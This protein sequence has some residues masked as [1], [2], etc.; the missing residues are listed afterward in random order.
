MPRTLSLSVLVGIVAV[1]ACSDVPTGVTLSTA[2]DRAVVTTPTSGIWART[3]VG[4]TGP[5]SSYAVYIPR[6]WNGDAVEYAHGFRDAASPVDLRDQDNL[7]AIRDL[8]GGL[9]YA[10]AYSS[11]DENGLAVK[12]GIQRTHQLRGLLAAQLGGRL[13]AHN[14]LVGSSL[15]GGIGV[16]LAEHYPEQYDGAFLMCGM[17]GGTLLQTQY[18]GH[19]RAL[20]D[21]FYPG[22]MPGSVLGVPAGEPIPTTEQVQA[23]VLGALPTNPLALYAIASTRQTPLPYVPG[24]NVL[25]PS[26]A[27]FQTMVYSLAYAVAWHARG[28]NNVLELTHGHTPFDN[29]STDYALGTPVVP[30]PLVP[31]ISTMIDDADAH[32]GRYTFDPSALNY[33]QQWYTPTGDVR[34]PVLT[35]HNTFDPGV[36]AFHEAALLERVQA[37]G[38]SDMLV[39]RYYPYAF[40]HCALPPSVV[41]QSFQDLANW[42][43]LGT[44]PAP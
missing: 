33:L 6:S 7:Y 2:A 29:H 27:S 36:P 24:G 32:V 17:V 35:L 9:G 18:V 28:M 13:P 25:D 12:D 31:T 10:V 41:V 20:F 34:I 4:Q 40:G 8:L 15:G 19:V 43:R 44:R 22:A 21:Y 42:A 37:A 30:A 11:F 39:Q 16:Y 14:F 26:S 3:V 1:A 23:R 38:R 5:G